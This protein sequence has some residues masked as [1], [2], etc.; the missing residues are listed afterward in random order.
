M[1]RPKG[2][3]AHIQS[4]NFKSLAL[5][6]WFFI[7]LQLLLI[8]VLATAMAIHRSTGQPIP[9]LHAMEL[10][11]DISQAA[12][13]PSTAS[14][15]AAFSSLGQ[16]AQAVWQDTWLLMQKGYTLWVVI[17]GL[18]YIFGGMIFAGFFTRRQTRARRVERSEEPRLY[19]LLEPLCIQRGLPMPKL[20]VIES[21]GCNAYASGMHPASSAIGVSRGL[22]NTLSDIELQSVLAHELAHI[23]NRDNR[24]MTLA[25]LCVAFIAPKSDEISAVLLRVWPLT[26]AAFIALIFVVPFLP[27]PFYLRTFAPILA[28][29]YLFSV[30]TYMIKLAVSRKREFIADAR[31]IEMVKEPA[32]L[33]SA[34][35]KISRNDQID[36]LNPNLQAMMI[37]NLSNGESWTHPTIEQRISAL[38][39]TTNVTLDAALSQAAPANRDVWAGQT[40]PGF[41]RRA[42]PA[43]PDMTATGTSQM[44]G[45]LASSQ[46][47]ASQLTSQEKAYGKISWAVDLYNWRKSFKLKFFFGL[48]AL[49]LATQV[50]PLITII[51]LAACFFL[52][53]RW[54]PELHA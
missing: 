12:N 33:I 4:N 29:A 14:R 15:E 11:R 16:Y 18:I 25:S 2:L 45:L 48:W 40:T 49:G 51:I 35:H 20:E 46:P 1:V 38:T 31:S 42:N 8:T 43:A 5:F 23:E 22:L 6:I 19:G 37:S 47:A 10:V 9:G 36:G 26:I 30:S 34:L 24:L 3:Y 53:R 21:P 27:L 32:A 50:L 44:R 52:Y 17:P 28:I 54:A 13:A 39:A 7:L 41:G